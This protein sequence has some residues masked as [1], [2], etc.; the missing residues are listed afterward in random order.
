MP[1]RPAIAKA[2]QLRFETFCGLE[3]WHPIGAM[4]EEIL[5][6]LRSGHVDPS[7]V[8]KLWAWSAVWADA[9]PVL[10]AFYVENLSRVPHDS[11]EY[12][13]LSAGLWNMFEGYP[14]SGSHAGMLHGMYFDTMGTRPPFPLTRGHH[15]QARRTP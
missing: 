15:A 2:L 8:L 11:P 7:D 13:A 10:K 6:G 4:A 3:G 12:A 5:H 9:H 14:V 1:V